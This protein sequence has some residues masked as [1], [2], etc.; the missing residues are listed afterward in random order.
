MILLPVDFARRLK[1]NF[2]RVK[3][4]KGKKKSRNLSTADFEGILVIVA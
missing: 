2:P 1:E 4:S 3:F